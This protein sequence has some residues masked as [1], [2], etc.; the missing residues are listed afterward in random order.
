MKWLGSY[1]SLLL[2]VERG[3]DEAYCN[4]EEIS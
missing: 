2:G 1:I 4:N 3:K